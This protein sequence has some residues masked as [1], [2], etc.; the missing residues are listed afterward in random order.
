LA[1]STEAEVKSFLLA[2]KYAIQ[3]GSLLF[4]RGRQ[5]NKESMVRLGID[6]ND[7]ASEVMSLSV[8][9]YCDGPLK[10]REFEGEIWEFGKEVTGKEVYI[11][12][13]LGGDKR[14]QQVIVIS[15]HIAEFQ[16]SYRFKQS[17]KK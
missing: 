2:V 17:L 13:K 16:L 10:D 11:K 12:L 8:N 7:V 5:K 6:L 1:N 3:D 4:R 14:N 15:F 9:D